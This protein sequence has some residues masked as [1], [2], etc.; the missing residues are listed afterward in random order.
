MPDVAKLVDRYFAIWNEQDGPRRRALIA[1]TWSETA[2]YVDPKLNAEGHEGLDAM[3]RTV[4]EHYPGLSFR[5]LGE[6]DAH[7]DRIRFAWSFAPESGQAL[8]RGLDV[9][10]IASDGRLQAV[11][12]FFDE[13]R[14][15]A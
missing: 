4:Q 1:E 9:A 8:A 3:V 13:L 5:R 6:I 2:T 10:V 15:A 14:V 11:T 12:G 7:H